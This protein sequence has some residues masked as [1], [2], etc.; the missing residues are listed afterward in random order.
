MK[1]GDSLEATSRVR[2]SELFDLVAKKLFPLNPKIKLRLISVAVI[3]ESV[4]TIF[5]I[6][7]ADDPFRVRLLLINNQLTLKMYF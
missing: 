3:H 2:L 4:K 5:S 1:E 7:V 6:S